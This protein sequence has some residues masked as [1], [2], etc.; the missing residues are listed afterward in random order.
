MAAVIQPGF[1]SEAAQWQQHELFPAP[2]HQTLAKFTTNRIISAGSENENLAKPASDK[3]APAPYA[4]TH[5][6]GVQTCHFFC[7][8]KWGKRFETDVA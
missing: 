8:K 5:A 4:L 6:K 2:S 3:P 7:T 1:N